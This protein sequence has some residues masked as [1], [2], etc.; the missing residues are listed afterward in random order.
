[1]D[2]VSEGL[3]R[4]RQS[5]FEPDS[6]LNAVCLELAEAV[7]SERISRWTMQKMIRERFP[8]LSEASLTQAMIS[9]LGSAEGDYP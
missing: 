3:P 4:R 7:R 9:A 5:L 8:A 1:M 2:R 6:E